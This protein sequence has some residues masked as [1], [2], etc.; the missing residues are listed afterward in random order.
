MIFRLE[1]PVYNAMM[2]FGNDFETMFPAL[3][4]E[5]GCVG[6]TGTDAN[7]GMVFMFVDSTTR[8]WKSDLAHECVHAANQM[9]H[10]RG[11]ETTWD[12]DEALAYMVGFM[13]EHALSALVNKTGDDKFTFEI[14]PKGKKDGY[15]RNS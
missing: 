12:N 4:P 14:K 15:K 2:I 1:I 3:E 8:E 9:L 6:H 7:T 10:G 11:V 13:F 5:P